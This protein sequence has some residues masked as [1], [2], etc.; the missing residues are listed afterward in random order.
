MTA[1]TR[2]RLWLRYQRYAF[3]LV[4]APLTWVALAIA[5]APWWL[6]GIAVL[7]AIAPVRFG[8]IVAARWPRKLRATYLARARIERGSFAPS[9]IKN[10]CGDP[11][12][13]LVADE[14]L[15]YAAI[16]RSERHR[17]IHEYREQLRLEDSMLVLVDHVRGTV[18]M[19]GG[20]SRERA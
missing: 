9:S 20:D 17:I 19:I 5:F 4:G 11:C 2:A 16:A 13:R 6:V 14:I 15:T 3:V 1:W 12:F 7:A 18:T 10:Y 8:V